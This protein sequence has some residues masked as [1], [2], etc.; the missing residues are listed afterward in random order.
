M[1]DGKDWSMRMLTGSDQLSLDAGWYVIVHALAANSVMEI[2]VSF[3][4]K[5]KIKG[6]TDK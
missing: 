2:K 3:L 4:K 6:S 5:E 1:K